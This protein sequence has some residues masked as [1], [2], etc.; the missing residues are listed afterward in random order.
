MHRVTIT[1]DDDLMEKLDTIIA[2]RGYQNRSEAIRD[3]ARIGIQQTAA[4]TTSGHC[5]GAMVYTYD[6]AKRGLPGKLTQS[7]HHHHELSRATM[8][9][10]LDHDQCLEVTILDGNAS[11]LQHFADHIFAER[12][13]RYGRLVTIPAEPGE[14]PHA[15]DQHEASS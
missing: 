5:V 6:H 11:E 2:A 14:E 8:H 7:F 12:G 9:V 3:L 15:P 10:H 4:E 1:L 13:V